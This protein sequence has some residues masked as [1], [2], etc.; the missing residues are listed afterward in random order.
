MTPRCCQC[1]DPAVARFE[2]SRGCVVFP[3]DRSQYLCLHHIVRA[4]PLGGME[5]V[6]DLTVD[7]AFRA[8]WEGGRPGPVGY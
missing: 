3:D 7:G 4:T 8:W 6:E 5:L 1:G 2:M